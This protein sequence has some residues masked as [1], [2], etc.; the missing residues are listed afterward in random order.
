MSPFWGPFWRPFWDQIGPRRDQKESKRA[1]ESL[2][3]PKSCILKNLKKA[4]VFQGFWGPDA[5]QESLKRPKKAP[6]RHP[7]SFKT[8]KK[9]DP[10]IEPKKLSFG[11]VLGTKND[12][13]TGT[14]SVQGGGETS[15]RGQSRASKNQKKAFSLKV[16]KCR[17]ANAKL[18]FLTFGDPKKAKCDPILEPILGP[19]IGTFFVIFGVI[20]WTTF[21]HL[22]DHF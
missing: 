9:R 18:Q 4:Y 12:T 7:E 1:I 10:K 14:R 22:L 17:Q 20:F 2:K 13:K 5:S 6:K 11:P 16:K 15:Q 21:G 19:K 3:D 8:S